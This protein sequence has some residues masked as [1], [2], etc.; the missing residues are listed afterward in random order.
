MGGAVKAVLQPFGLY[1]E[2]SA[3]PI[4]IPPAPKAPPV[5]PSADEDA[6]KRA[7]QATLQRMY[8]RSGRQSTILSDYATGTDT[9]G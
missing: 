1:Q 7:R 8:R 5:M 4:V 9:L 3:A 6:R 2:P